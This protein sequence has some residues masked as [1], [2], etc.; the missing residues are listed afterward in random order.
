VTILLSFFIDDIIVFSSNYEDHLKHINTVFQRLLQHK[1]KLKFKKCQFL[2]AET[3][4]LGFVVNQ[5]RIKPN[6]NKIKAIR[7]LAPPSNPNE[8][9]RLLGMTV[10]LLGLAQKI[11]LKLF[12]F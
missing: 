1:L 6:P 4:F 2:K 10:F 7:K 12:H 8:T 5:H 11:T 3:E 9:R